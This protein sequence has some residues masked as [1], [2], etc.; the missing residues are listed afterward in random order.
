M[1]LRL[2]V[3]FGKTLLGFWCRK[4]S[5]F[6]STVRYARYESYHAL[7]SSWIRPL[8]SRLLRGSQSPFDS[9][10]VHWAACFAS[11]VHRMGKSEHCRLFYC[12]CNIIMRFNSDLTTVYREGPLRLLLHP[13]SLTWSSK[14]WSLLG[15]LAYWRY[16]TSSVDSKKGF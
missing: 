3:L 16:V 1:V 12:S 11:S 2:P 4:D 10:S 15:L 6:Y 5:K 14:K 9:K 13:H 8:W 7:L